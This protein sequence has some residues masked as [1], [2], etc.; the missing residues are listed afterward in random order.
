MSNEN[1]RHNRFGSGT[2]S[3]LD[4]VPLVNLRASGRL[5][6][7]TMIRLGSYVCVSDFGISVSVWTGFRFID[8]I[9][10]VPKPLDSRRSVSNIFLNNLSQP[11]SPWSQNAPNV[12]SVSSSSGGYKN[13][14]KVLMLSSHC[15]H[16]TSCEV[17]DHV[18]KHSILGAFECSNDEVSKFCFRGWE[19]WK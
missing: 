12:C 1:K 14:V 17:T 5:W 19:K 16:S 3:H 7:C 2:G 13:S 8:K 18:S 6:S 9:L 10:V 11:N 15:G 4:N